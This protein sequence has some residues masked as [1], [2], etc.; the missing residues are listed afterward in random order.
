MKKS[1]RLARGHQRGAPD[2]LGPFGNARIVEFV[3]LEHTSVRAQPDCPHCSRQT[4]A[5]LTGPSRFLL[6]S[7][8]VTFKLKL[9]ASSSRRFPTGPRPIWC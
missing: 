7:L 2:G 8:R 5:S 3:D 1:T 6:F 9:Q 4:F